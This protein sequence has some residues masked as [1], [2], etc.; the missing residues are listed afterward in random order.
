MKEAKIDFEKEI[1]SYYDPNAF[2]PDWW[3]VTDDEYVSILENC[4]KV[5][6]INCLVKKKYLKRDW[7]SWWVISCNKIDYDKITE[8]LHSEGHS[9]IRYREINT[10]LWT[11]EDKTYI[12][13]IK[14]K[15]G[16]G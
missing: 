6:Q 14:K 13:D 4:L 5:E 9:K 2:D 1:M 7:N 16:N 11:F 3:L 15:Q 8:I 10:E 12:S